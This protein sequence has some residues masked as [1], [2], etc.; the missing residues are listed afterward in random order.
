MEM[1]VFVTGGY[2]DDSGECVVWSL[3]FDRGTHE[4]VLRW[5]PPDFLRVPGKGFA[6]GCIG[7]DG[8]LYVAAHAAVVK[9][10]PNR[11]KVL[12][13]L[14]QPCMNDVHH[15]ACIQ[16]RIYI[17]NTGLESVD[18]F[19]KR[20]DFMGSH[21]LLPSWVNARRMMGQEPSNWDE[22]LHVG[23]NPHERGFW[24]TADETDDYHT[25]NRTIG[26][27]HQ[28]K[29]RDCFH[30][31]HVA[32]HNGSVL[33]TCFRTGSLRDLT[34]HKTVFQR[35]EAYLHD[36]LIVDESIWLSAI[37]GRLFEIDQQTYRA[38]KTLEVFDTGHVGWCRGLAL[39]KKGMLVGLTQVRRE[40]MPR[41]RWSDVSPDNSE[42]S[43]LLIS[44]Q[45]GAL[46]RRI[47]ITDQQ[48]HSKIYS[49]LIQDGRTS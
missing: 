14:H 45:N 34:N 32:I 37:D 43:V 31:N 12:G 30:I 48:R 41:H 27:F 36:G 46:K 2:F 19:S 9:I 25:K 38:K 49:I 35:E 4:V 22:C 1:N 18:V 42:T 26:S 6:G 16:D 10:D 29:V 28:H 7:D 39:H 20:G 13:V 11:W 15:V 33:A 40:R 5:T 3:D 8:F 24:N 47:D 21:A 44:P 17:A 23:W